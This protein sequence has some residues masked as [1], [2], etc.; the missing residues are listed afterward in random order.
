MK[1][2]IF[3]IF[4]FSF[5]VSVSL[6]AATL[7][8]INSLSFSPDG[9]LLA[10]GSD[11]KTTKLWDVKS[12]SLIRTLSETSYVTSVAFSPDGSLLASGNYGKTI[13]LWDVKSGSLIRI[14]TG[15]L[16]GHTDPVY[17]VAFSPDGN[18]L[19]SGSS[20]GTLLFGDVEVAKKGQSVNPGSGK[21][22]STWGKIKS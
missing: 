12:G 10:S 16:T 6:F 19:A 21:L 15:P 13:K 18:L 22:A 8:S 3:I 20:D 14:L 17:S 2:F 7:V 11:D 4:S 5:L 9:N 1:R